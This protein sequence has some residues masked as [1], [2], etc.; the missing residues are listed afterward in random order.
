[1]Q[2][3]NSNVF[4]V[5][6]LGLPFMGYRV[7]RGW[8]TE[9]EVLFEEGIR[10]VGRDFTKLQTKFLPRKNVSEIVLYYY[11][12][13]KVKRT[14]AARIWYDEV[15]EEKMEHLRA[16]EKEEVYEDLEDSR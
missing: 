9:D 5:Q 3:G 11:N 12:I 6:D 13:W 16:K 10:S 2:H 8:T 1:M 4:S 7:R 14:H 15:Q